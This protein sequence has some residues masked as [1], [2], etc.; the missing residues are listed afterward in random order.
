MSVKVIPHL[1]GQR[2]VA[3]AASRLLNGT[4]DSGR[5]M[6]RDHFAGIQVTLVSVSHASFI[7]PWYTV[8]NLPF[9]QHLPFEELG[10]ALGSLK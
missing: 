1:V 9:G 3:S 5:I 6:F 7:E 2:A 8:V 10:L 4:R